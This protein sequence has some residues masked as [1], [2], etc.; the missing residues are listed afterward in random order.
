M[1]PPQAV[2]AAE[3]GSPTA[4]IRDTLAVCSWAKE[5]TWHCSTRHLESN[6]ATPVQRVPIL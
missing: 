3:S 6:A 4:S 5:A 2:V 1:K